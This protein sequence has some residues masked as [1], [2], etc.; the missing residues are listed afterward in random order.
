MADEL[1]FLGERPTRSDSGHFSVTAA[2]KNTEK[3]KGRQ[4]VVVS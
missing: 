3:N 1:V 2:K 4:D